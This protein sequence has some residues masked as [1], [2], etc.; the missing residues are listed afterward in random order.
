MGS[1]LISSI[2]HNKTMSSNPPSATTIETA[3]NEGK[4]I[5]SQLKSPSRLL[6]G[7]P[8]SIMSHTYST[9]T[10]KL[11]RYDLM[12][13]D[14]DIHISGD[15]N[16]DDDDNDDDAFVVSNNRDIYALTDQDD[17]DISN[18]NTSSHKNA[19]PPPPVL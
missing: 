9:V 11:A 19:A 15:Y 16:I 5:D 2:I 12:E 17:A 8:K 6:L 4:N 10:S 18:N 7:L 14:I 3:N 1:E 13:Q